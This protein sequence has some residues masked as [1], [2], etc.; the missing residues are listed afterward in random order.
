MNRYL[1][2]LKRFAP[3][4]A[5]LMKIGESIGKFFFLSPA[6]EKVAYKKLIC[7]AVERGEIAIAAGSKFLSRTGFGGFKRYPSPEA[8]FPPPNFLISSLD[9]AI[10]EFGS[11]KCPVIVSIPK[12]WAII[13]T[14]EYPSTV[15]E[16]LSEVMAYELDRITP[17]TPETAYYDFKILKE[18]ADRVFILVA[19]ARADL[20]DPYLRALKEKKVK[21]IGITVNLLGLAALCRHRRKTN[22]CLFIEIGKNHYE[23]FLL[24][25]DN[26]LEV[27]SGSF[28]DESEKLKLEQ[29]ETKIESLL[30]LAGQK[31]LR[32]EIFFYLKDKSP[33]LRELIK[34]QIRHSVQFLDESDIGIGSLGKDR[35]QVPYSAIGG[36]LE[37]LWPKS[38]GMNLLNKGFHRKSKPPWVVTLL[39]VLTLGVLVGIY[40]TTPVEIETKRLHDIEKQIALKKAEVKKV[41][42]L[43]K[44]IELVSGEID[45]INDFKQSR[46]LCLNILKELTVLLPKDSWL[47]R[48]RV[49]E[50]QVSIEGYSPSATLLIPKL[51]GS[52]FFK[53]VE[54]AAP[55][56]KDPRQNTDRFQIKM[57]LKSP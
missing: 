45:L 3:Y 44:E 4:W 43:K 37:S 7:L 11:E 14:V 18:E 48:V 23:G 50:S 30:P 29:I 15:L 40:W 26:A 6:D 33:T 46:P 19:A 1:N 57:E 52:K 2:N 10:A 16:N 21:I 12:A 35:K 41:D 56:F 49:F 24:F 53:K 25:S 31:E 22:H 28:T 47:T 39:L 27:F 5:S 42:N 8:G 17:F 51:E 20:V 13:K 34:L 36:V 38:W 32:G 54:F 55:T 9:L